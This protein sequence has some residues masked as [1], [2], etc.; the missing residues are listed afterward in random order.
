M[1]DNRQMLWS[2]LLNKVKITV[3]MRERAYRGNVSEMFSVRKSN[4]LVRLETSSISGSP[5]IF[6]W[7]SQPLSSSEVENQ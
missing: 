7:P 5:G 2:H 3:L 1:M 6:I 4:L